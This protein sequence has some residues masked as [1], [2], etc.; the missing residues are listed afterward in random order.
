MPDIPWDQFETAADD[1]L[2][3][4]GAWIARTHH[5][6]IG[7]FQQ[8]SMIGKESC[9]TKL[10]PLLGSFRLTKTAQSLYQIFFPLITLGARA[11]EL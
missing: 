9:A 11:Y 1:I 7:Y 4:V 8:V 2:E 3:P 6:N 5:P 10:A